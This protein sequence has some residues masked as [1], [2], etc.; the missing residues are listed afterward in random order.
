MIYAQYLI[1]YFDHKTENK[2]QKSYIYVD[3]YSTFTSYSL[4]NLTYLSIYLFLQGIT[5][6]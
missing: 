6:T 5:R 4:K 2:Q 3:I 1:T